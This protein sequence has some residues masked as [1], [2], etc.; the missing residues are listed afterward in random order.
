M[1]LAPFDVQVDPAMALDEYNSNGQD[2]LD[3]LLAILD[4]DNQVWLHTSRTCSC[5]ADILTRMRN[6]S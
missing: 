4:G 2:G 6:P 1:V 5:H 3:D